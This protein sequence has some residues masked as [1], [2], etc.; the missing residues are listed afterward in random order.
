MKSLTFWS[1]HRIWPTQFH[2]ICRAIFRR[3]AMLDWCECLSTQSSAG[4]PTQVNG[5]SHFATVTLR[6]RRQRDRSGHVLRSFHSTS[7]RSTPA[8]WSWRL[9]I[10]V[11]ST[12]NHWNYA[13]W[14]RSHSSR[15]DGSSSYWELA[16]NVLATAQNWPSSFGPV[17]RLC[18]WPIC[19]VF[20]SR[21]ANGRMGMCIC[22]SPMWLNSSGMKH[23]GRAE[24]SVSVWM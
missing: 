21:W 19:G 3:L 22:P 6:P 2:A 4:K 17:R 10:R 24:S 8:G 7:D 5:S 12:P 15:V 11:R 9:T 1:T 13:D 14:P 18:S 20:A 16:M 23:D